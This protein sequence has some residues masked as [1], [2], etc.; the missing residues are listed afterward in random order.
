MRT[1]DIYFFEKKNKYL[2]H[3]LSKIKMGASIASEPFIW[4]DANTG[5]EKVI[6]QILAVLETNQ[7]LLPNPVN[8]E[9]HSKDFLKKI[10]L[11]SIKDLHNNVKNIGILEKDGKIFF[12][13]MKNL[14]SKLGYVNVD[15][16]VFDVE[17]NA[18]I[19]EIASVLLNSLA[20][21]E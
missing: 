11:R 13:P 6:Q 3:G 16:K 12:T 9:S 7:I 14:G 19:S 5:I 2:I 1:A 4:I 18:S 21:C 20:K 8:W 10:G 17:K 15:E